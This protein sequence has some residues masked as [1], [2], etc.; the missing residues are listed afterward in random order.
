MT[1]IHSAP[2]IASLFIVAT[3]GCD[4]RLHRMAGSRERIS[5]PGHPAHLT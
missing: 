5:G 1:L 4:R 3:T 2:A